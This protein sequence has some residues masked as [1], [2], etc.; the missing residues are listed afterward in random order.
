MAALLLP[1][2]F[3]FRLALACPRVDDLPRTGK[4]A[5]RLDLP[6]SGKLVAP[7]LWEGRQPFAE[8]R[9]AWNPRGLALAVEVVGK[10]GRIPRVPADRDFRD[11]VTIWIDTRD[12]R[13]VHRA[14]RY[15]HQFTASI[16]ASGSGP[17]V[18]LEARPIARAMAHPPR[19]P[20]EA[21][22]RRVEVLR[23]GWTL[24][25]F[26]GA[27][28]LHGFDPDTSRRLG[29]MVQVIDPLQGEQ[30][31]GVGREFPIDTDPSLWATLELCDEPA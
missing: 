23:A 24:E 1:P 8:I 4:R 7:A 3:W 20:L 18:E 19:T 2:P 9:A 5:G 30:F 31:L 25:L 6:E 26:F 22:Q 10:P 14:T 16:D 13:D 12:T 28:S 27:E 21:V 17:A 15:C 29:L 11:G